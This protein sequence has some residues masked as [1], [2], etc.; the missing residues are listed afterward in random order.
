MPLQ[1]RVDPYGKLHA[2]EARGAWMGNRGILHDD[3]Q[4][5]IAPWRLKR[6]ITCTLSFRGRQRQV[7]APHRYSELF[8]LDEAT[9]FAAGHRPC[10]ECRRERYNEFRAAWIAVNL[11]GAPDRVPGADD[12]DAVLHSERAIRGGGKRTWQ[13]EPDALPSGT[14]IEHGERPHVIWAGKLWPWSFS[15]YG[16]PVP[17]AAAAAQAAVLTPRSIVRVF[18]AGFRLQ[19]H[20]SAG[21]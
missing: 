20:E 5:I 9:S 19:V 8:F 21:G 16:K 6:W 4:R 1:N 2:V 17:L 3:A 14:I 18:G 7:F 15:G 12:I 11:D 10:A 13:A